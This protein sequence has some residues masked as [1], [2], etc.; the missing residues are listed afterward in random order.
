MRNATLPPVRSPMPLPLPFDDSPLPT[1]QL[2]F[3]EDGDEDGSDDGSE[4]T[5]SEGTVF[6]DDE[7][8]DMGDADDEGGLESEEET[9]EK[10]EEEA[11][12]MDEDEEKGEDEG[13]QEAENDDDSSDPDSDDEEYWKTTTDPLVISVPWSKVYE[14][15]HFRGKTHMLPWWWGS[16]DVLKQRGIQYEWSKPWTVEEQLEERGIDIVVQCTVDFGPWS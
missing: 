9:E 11:E 4:S 5:V 10:D 8:M 13:S 6:G 15:E 12:E 7:E 16:K 2:S 14:D 1:M 3:G